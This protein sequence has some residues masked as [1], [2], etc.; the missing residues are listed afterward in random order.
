MAHPRKLRLL[1]LIRPAPKKETNPTLR[2]HAP[3]KHTSDRL[4][5]SSSSEGRQQS[6][7]SRRLIDDTTNLSHIGA[8]RHHTHRPADTRNRGSS[9]SRAD[10]KLQKIHNEVPVSKSVDNNCGMNTGW[11]TTNSFRNDHMGFL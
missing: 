11:V 9:M 2:E 4:G 7:D 8:G 10:I 5:T 1:Q 6:K 3:G